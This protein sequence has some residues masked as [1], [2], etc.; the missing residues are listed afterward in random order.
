MTQS[1]KG[2]LFLKLWLRDS[3]YIVQYVNFISQ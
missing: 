2:K 3:I 1:F